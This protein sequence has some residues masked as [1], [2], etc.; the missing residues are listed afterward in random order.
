LIPRAERANPEQIAIDTEKKNFLKANYLLDHD[1]NTKELA[2]ELH[3]EKGFCYQSI[4]NSET[5]TASI[6]DR[7]IYK[8]RRMKPFGKEGRPNSLYFDEILLLQDWINLRI[9]RHEQPTV[10]EIQAKVF[11]MYIRIYGT[12]SG[13]KYH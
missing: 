9:L 4:I 7:A 6:L 2:I 10:A 3:Y 12:C 5:V 13:K 8:F 1:K 11:W